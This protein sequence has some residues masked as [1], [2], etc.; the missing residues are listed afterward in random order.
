MNE[1]RLPATES[2]RSDSAE[3]V[4][5]LPSDLG[6]I[7][8]AVTYLVG[9]CRAFDFKGPRLDLNFRVGVT[10]ALANAV[11]YGND[12]DPGKTVRIDVSVDTRR[13]EV[14]VTDQGDGFDPRRIP[15]PTTPENIESPGG[16]GLFLIRHLMDEMEFNDRGNAVRMV[17]TRQAPSNRR[18]TGY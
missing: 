11:L 14:R 18:S 12:S 17:L 3:F 8:A 13:V 6:L 10:E 16:R 5:D 1:D 15:D 9:R 4:I 2:G 7:E